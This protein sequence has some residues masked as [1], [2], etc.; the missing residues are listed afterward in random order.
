MMEI[1][2][3]AVRWISILTLSVFLGWLIFQVFRL[4]LAE[5]VASEKN[6]RPGAWIEANWGGLGGG[7]SGWRASNAIIYLLLMSLLLGCLSL[8]VVSLTSTNEKKK[9]QSQDEQEK[10]TGKKGDLK[11]DAE[12][13]ED[14]SGEKK[15]E[16]KQPDQKAD[17]SKPADSATGGKNGKK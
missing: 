17:E 6:T 14:K 10:D 9:D 1:L 8:A 11:K 2:N 5:M 3:W 16:P 7:L 12:K 4:F 13:K 15:G